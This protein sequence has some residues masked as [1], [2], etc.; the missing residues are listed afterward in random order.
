[1]AIRRKYGVPDNGLDEY[2]TEPNPHDPKN[3]FFDYPESTR[4]PEFDSDVN[5]ILREYGFPEGWFYPFRDLIVYDEFD[6]FGIEDFEVRDMASRAKFEDENPRYFGTLTK[7]LGDWGLV[8]IFIHPY[9][10][11]SEILDFVRNSY[12]SRIEPIQQKY[13]D[14]KVKAGKV[15]KPNRLKA[16]RDAYILELHGKGQKVKEIVGAVAKKYE[17]DPMDYSYV[18]KIIRKKKS[19]K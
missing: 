17:E 8:G 10:N 15:R 3:P 9:A 6:G 12:E 19:G 18:Y 16:K 13:R 7:Q 5:I 4:G 1:M 2:V 11:K 14:P